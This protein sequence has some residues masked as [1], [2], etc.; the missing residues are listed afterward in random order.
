MRHG[1][2]PNLIGDGYGVKPRYNCRDS[3]WYWIY[4]II[5]YEDM[6]QNVQLHS[7]DN[8]NL[9]SILNENVWRWFPTDDALGW[10]D[11]I[12]CVSNKHSTNRIQKLY[13]VM[14]DALQSH[15]SK[16]SFIERNAGPQLD[17][18]MKPD[19]FK[20]GFIYYFCFMN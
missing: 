20:V 9:K 17:E 12:D 8:L 7:S 3:V 15:F 5:C 19:G 16:I 14:Q 4:T 6:I 10:P 18:H 13:D 2:I 11:E 1:L